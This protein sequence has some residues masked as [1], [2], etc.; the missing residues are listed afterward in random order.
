MYVFGRHYYQQLR[1]HLKYHF[2]QYT[3]CRELNT[4]PWVLGIASSGVIV[5]KQGQSCKQHSEKIAQ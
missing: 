1:V 5:C 2:F 3:S 4:R